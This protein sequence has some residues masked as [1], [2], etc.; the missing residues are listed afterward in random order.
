MHK[1][2]DLYTP[3]ELLFL[4]LPPEQLIWWVGITP[5]DID[6]LLGVPRPY[7]YAGCVEWT[8]SNCTNLSNK[9]TVVAP[10]VGACDDRKR[11]VHKSV[12]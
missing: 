7:H 9:T 8:K 4:S 2:H 10:L 3:T 5:T 6:T 1:P 11:T 12:S